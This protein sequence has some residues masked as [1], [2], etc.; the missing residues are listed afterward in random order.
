VQ[1]V[2]STKIA[3]FETSTMISPS[4]L[5]DEEVRPSEESSTVTEKIEESSTA[6]PEKSE[7]VVQ[8]KG[9]KDEA[10][11]KIHAAVY[12]NK[13]VVHKIKHVFGKA[14]LGKTDT[15][16]LSE[17]EKESLKETSTSKQS[18][19]DIS[20]ASTTV[21]SKLREYSEGCTR[22]RKE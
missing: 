19:E 4:P 6:P 17:T 16:D 7:K 9:S 21:G 18:Q 3:S 15:E 11:A 12:K 22:C 1:Y 13:T 20:T 10:S 14:M 8:T 2:A 5:Q